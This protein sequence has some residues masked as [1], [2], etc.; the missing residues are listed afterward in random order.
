MTSTTDFLAGLG[1]A[2]NNRTMQPARHSVYV[3]GTKVTFSYSGLPTV[4]GIKARA[5]ITAID[6]NA[7]ESSNNLFEEGDDNDDLFE[8]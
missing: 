8:V 7:P 6:P 1:I 2:A 4:R 5:N 3:I